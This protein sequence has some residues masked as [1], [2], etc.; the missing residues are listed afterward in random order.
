MKYLV[1]LLV[2]VIGFWLWRNRRAED[3]AD[4]AENHRPAEA[5]APALLEIV[6]CPIC[7][8]HLPANE[9]VAGQR[10]RYCSTDHRRQAEG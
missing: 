6:A 8:L 4:R 1:V 5:P 10:A 9:S 7:G 2:V 3:A